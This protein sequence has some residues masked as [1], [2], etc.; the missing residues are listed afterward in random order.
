MSQHCA[1]CDDGRFVCEN[2]PDRP[3]EGE[4]ACDCGGA[5]MPCPACNPSEVTLPEMP[6]DFQKDLSVEPIACEPRK[7]PPA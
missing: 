4:R 2:H 6:D 3:W 7:N 1:V 5:G